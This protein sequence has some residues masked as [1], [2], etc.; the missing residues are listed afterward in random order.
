MAGTQGSRVC[1]GQGLLQ[2][3]LP[4]LRVFSLSATP[5]HEPWEGPALGTAPSQCYREI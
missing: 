1:Q 4:F 5:R 2:P 3:C